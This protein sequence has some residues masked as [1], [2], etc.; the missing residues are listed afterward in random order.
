M[1]GCDAMHTPCTY[2]V[3]DMVIS[4]VEANSEYFRLCGCRSYLVQNPTSKELMDIGEPAALDSTHIAVVGRLSYEKRP[5][6][7]IAVFKKVH[8]ERPDAVL[9]FVGPDNGNYTD[10]INR[11]CEE[12]G[13]KDSVKLHGELSPEAVGDI[14]H[15]AAMM[16]LTSEVEG[17]GLVL[18]ESKAHGL[19]IV[20]YD[21]PYLSTVKDRKG[22]LTSEIGDIDNMASDVLKLL[23]DD[24]LRH[25]YGNE[26]LESFEQFK[27]YD[28]EGT[29]RNIFE[30]SAVADC[31][32]RPAEYYD[33]AD[34]SDTEK[35][36]SPLLLNAL[37]DNLHHKPD[38]YATADY[39]L[40]HRLLKI[41]RLIKHSVRK[42][43][44]NQKS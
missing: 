37:L 22:I 5:M 13:L 18:I 30:L 2:S 4:L 26:S 21:L 15:D 20:M 17:Y 32:I 25:R 12:Y 40:G 9:D 42:I 27:T 31:D 14:M 24:A 34:L 23:N 8:D 6:D 39:R 38:V 1:M 36:I 33:P 19:P 10:E 29:W 35:F 41:P 28:L 44:G 11:F 3:T 7:A 16:L 43:F